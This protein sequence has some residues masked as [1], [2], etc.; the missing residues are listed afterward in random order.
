MN[1]EKKYFY[2]REGKDKIARRPW[3]AKTIGMEKII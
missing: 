2:P 1:E 3:R